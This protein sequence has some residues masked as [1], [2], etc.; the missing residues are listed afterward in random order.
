MIL[1]NDLHVFFHKL[2]RHKLDWI[3][4]YHDDFEHLVEE[5]QEK[6]KGIRER[7]SKR[8]VDLKEKGLGKIICNITT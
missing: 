4:K 2:L 8:I 3:T 6:F 1:E 5:V 7:Y